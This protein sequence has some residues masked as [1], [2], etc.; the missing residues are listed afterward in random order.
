MSNNTV[1][2]HDRNFQVLIE[3]N[4][5]SRQIKKL[6]KE[7]S[8]YYGKKGEVPM[9]ISV[10]HGAVIFASD[11]VRAIDIPVEMDFV[12]LKSYSG[13][14]ST[15][16]VLMTQHWEK[17]VSGREVLIVEDIIDSGAS[18][19]FLKQELLKAGASDVKIS[20]LLFKPDA[21][22]FD[23]KID[24]VGFSISNKFVLGFGLDYDGLGRN[25]PEIYQLCSE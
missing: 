14:T 5:L 8:T 11:L 20:T 9:V 15:G 7:I 13:M 2:V 25:L 4:D 22:E 10:L 17:E 6:G 21:F 19:S 24:W 23:Y 1:K 18:I 12:R 3:K 16:K